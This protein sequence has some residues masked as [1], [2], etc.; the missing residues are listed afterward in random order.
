MRTLRL[1]VPILAALSGMALFSVT[2]ASGQGVGNPAPGIERGVE[3]DAERDADRIIRLDLIEVDRKLK[4]IRIEAEALTVDMPL[5]F[6]AVV[7]GGPEHEAMFRTAAKPSVIHTGLLMLGLEPG[8]PMKF[9]P[10]ANRWSPP[11]GPP[12]RV[13]IEWQ[14]NG[15][16]RREPVGRLIRGIKN[17][18]PMPD[19]IFVFTGSVVDEQKRYLADL[20][21]YVISLSNFELTMIDVP[22][23]SSSANELLEWECNPDFGPKRGTPVTLILRAAGKDD[24]GEALPPATIGPRVVIVKLARDGSIELE[25]TAV[26]DTKELVETLIKRKETGPFEVRLAADPAGDAN[27]SLA[28]MQSLLQAAIPVKLSNVAIHDEASSD[29]NLIELREQW[30][31]VVNPHSRAMR[32]AAATHY[33]VIAEL[34]EKQQKLIN[35]SDK[36]QRLI[37]ELERD[38]ADMTT[39]RPQ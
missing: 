3:R 27:A 14:E 31:K 17:K 30:K 32:D 9:S 2:V 22:S 26:Q 39:P 10:A 12:I 38:Y 1:L 15:V 11:Y 37:E 20:A 33:K 19:P 6:V 34:R 21:G 18:L 4:E 13:E 25:G 36:I 7:N 8:A 35:E 23:L 16:V 24:V 29:A 5:E 28:V